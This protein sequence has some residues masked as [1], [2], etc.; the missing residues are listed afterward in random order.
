MRTPISVAFLTLAIAACQSPITS[1]A[2]TV[3]MVGSDTMAQS[4]LPALT[5][6]F[7]AKEHGVAIASEGGGTRAGFRAMLADQ[8][9]LVAASSPHTAAEEEQARV[10]GFTLD[11]GARRHLIGMDVAAVTVHPDNPIGA[12]SY[13]QVIGIFCTAEI[14]DWGQLGQ[15]PGP[16]HAVGRTTDSATRSLFE[17]FFCGGPGLHRSIPELSAGQVTAA[18]RDD[19][20]VISFVSRSEHEGRVVS[21]RSYPGA[22]PVAPS[23]VNVVTGAYP[24]A[25]DLFVYEHPSASEEAKDFVAFVLSDAGQKVVESSRFVPLLDRPERVRTDRP[26]KGI[27]HFEKSAAAVDPQGEALLADL[28]MEL[29]GR[30]G[31]VNHVVLEGF[32]DA[33]ERDPYGLSRRR[34][35]AVEERL[36]EELPG[37]LFEIIPRGP[38]RPLGPNETLAGQNVNR[39][40]QVFLALEGPQVVVR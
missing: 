30:V 5:D 27:L 37:T 20:Q 29:R 35:A 19:R 38:T 34:A 24:L 18:L 28:A 12:L 31:D 33:S 22:P 21:L 4:L 32:A 11:D 16:I 25:R 2:P 1:S 39:R 40:V 10:K 26:L 36:K 14:T 3:I 8:A 13:D 17:G 6:A 23:H 15:D 7:H 9:E